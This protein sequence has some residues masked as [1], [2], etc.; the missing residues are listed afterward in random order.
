M[1][2]TDTTSNGVD[3]TLSGI[4]E[5]FT[6]VAGLVTAGGNG[7]AAVIFVAVMVVIVVSLIFG[8]KLTKDLLGL[9]RWYL[10]LG[11]ICIVLSLAV[12]VVD[13]FLGKTYDLYVSV[14]PSLATVGYPDPVVRADAEVVPTDTKFPV[15]RSMGINVIFDATIEY[16]KKQNQN[17]V[18]ARMA[19]QDAAARA[20]ALEETLA[21]QTVQMQVI[22]ASFE[23]L[24][25]GG[26][27]DWAN[28]QVEAIG[29]SLNTFKL[30][31]LGRYM[32]RNEPMDDPTLEFRN[33]P[34]NTLPG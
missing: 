30:D 31:E 13:Q 11:T 16:V 26:L 2:A 23:T 21:T 8:A 27:P 28:A 20:S 32:V 14:S 24:K 10:A 18:E 5:I 34:G 22:Q 25:A 6:S 29:T 17:L 3:G 7:L 33:L 4:A 1:T 9:I 19:E 15:N 12:G